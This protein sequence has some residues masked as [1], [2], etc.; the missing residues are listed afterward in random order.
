MKVMTTMDNYYNNNGSNSSSTSSNS[1]ACIPRDNSSPK[2]VTVVDKD[3]QARLK[4][5]ETDNEKFRRENVQLRDTNEELVRENQELRS[6][7]SSIG[8]QGANTQK[9]SS[10]MMQVEKP[11]AVQ[12]TISSSSEQD[13]NRWEPPPRRQQVNMMDDPLFQHMA[14]LSGKHQPSHKDEELVRG[15]QE[16][17]SELSKN[18]HHGSINLKYSSS[19]QVDENKSQSAVQGTLPYN[20]VTRSRESSFSEQ[21]G[22]LRETPPRRQQ[23]GIM[24][25]PLF[26]HMAHLSGNCQANNPWNVSSST[27]SA[28]SSSHQGHFSLQVPSAF[29]RSQY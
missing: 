8:R 26:Q 15:N 5:L 11:P 19:M 13:E 24:D 28:P 2:D 17:R 27:G 7:L 20:N 16:V 29:T 22:S 4:K 3:M 12:T 23:G 14:Q 18:T 6:K 1:K 9:H 25:D 10:S 21:D